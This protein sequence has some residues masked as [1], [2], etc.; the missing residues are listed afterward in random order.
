MKTMLPTKSRDRAS[1][2]QTGKQ[3]THNEQG[4]VIVAF[5]VPTVQT[6]SEARSGQAAPLDRLGLAVITG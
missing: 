5:P 1:S 2:K 3:P 6:R 4:R